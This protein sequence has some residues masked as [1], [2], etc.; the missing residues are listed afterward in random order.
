MQF[1]YV[2][3]CWRGNMH[4]WR[5]RTII[6][7]IILD[8]LK[9]VEIYCGDAVEERIDKVEAKLNDRNG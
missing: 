2:A 1:R 7:Q 9:L 5:L 4:G 6:S 3:R 8:S